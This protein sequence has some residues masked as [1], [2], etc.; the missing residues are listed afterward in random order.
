M[1]ISQLTGDQK[2][3]LDDALLFGRSCRIA[4]AVT[5]KLFRKTKKAGFPALTIRRWEIESSA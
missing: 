1:D 5:K 4:S 2:E 3:I